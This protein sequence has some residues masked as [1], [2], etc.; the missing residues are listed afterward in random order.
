MVKR[1]AVLF[2]DGS[3]NIISNRN[4]EVAA[5]NEAR[6]ECRAWN[7]GERKSENLAQFGEIEIDLVSFR[8]RF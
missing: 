8:E 2:P 4:G 5:V 7:K 6:D 1:I 3:A